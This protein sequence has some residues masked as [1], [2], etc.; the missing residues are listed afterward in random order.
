[1]ISSSR[2]S[3]TSYESQDKL[4]TA[5]DYWRIGNCGINGNGEI[6]AILDTGINSDVR[7]VINPYPIDEDNWV[8]EDPNA[9]G[10]MVAIVAGSRETR[11]LNSNITCSFTRGVAPGAQLA[12]CKVAKESAR[13]YDPDK[14]LK[15]L[16]LIYEHNNKE[17]NQKIRLVVMPFRLPDIAYGIEKEIEIKLTHLQLQEVICVVAAGNDG[18]NASPNFPAK[19]EKVLT[20]GSVDAFGKFSSFSSDH[21]CID[22]LAPGTN[23]LFREYFYGEDRRLITDSG[24]SYAAPAVAGLIARLFEC[25][26]MHGDEETLSRLSDLPRLKK[27]LKKH[28][29]ESKLLQ[30]AKVS[31]F[32]MNPPENIATLTKDLD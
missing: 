1:M 8:D 25:A 12:I 22:V 30:P 26:R 18:K 5:S 10:S 17:S 21:E 16:S 20:V 32:F 6:I 27:F 4:I 28:L 7:S 9:H 15:Y 3:A 23:I 13:P 2:Q 24:T 11:S 19:S 31:K 29:C 14:V